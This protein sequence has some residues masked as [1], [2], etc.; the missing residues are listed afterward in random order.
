MYNNTG[1]GINYYFHVSKQIKSYDKL[2]KQV[3]Q[4]MNT[5]PSVTESKA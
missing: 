5:H 4:A 2:T 1:P 3:L